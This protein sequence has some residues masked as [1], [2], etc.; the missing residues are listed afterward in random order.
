VNWAGGCVI[1]VVWFIDSAP[2]A[3][4]AGGGVVDVVWFIDDAQRAES[5]GGGVVDGVWFFDRIWL[6]RRELRVFSDT[7]TQEELS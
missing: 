3:E 4:S 1:D 2:R 5:A 7:S 6:Y